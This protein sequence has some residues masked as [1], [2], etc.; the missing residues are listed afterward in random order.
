MVVRARPD[1]PPRGRGQLIGHDRLHLGSPPSPP[2]G[3][4]LPGIGL[5]GPGHRRDQPGIRPPGQ[6]PAPAP[7]DRPRPDPRPDPALASRA[8]T[9]PVARP[10]LGKERTGLWPH[11]DLRHDPSSPTHSWS[12]VPCCPRRAV[13][14]TASGRRVKGPVGRGRGTSQI[15]VVAPVDAP[16]GPPGRTLS[17]C[18]AA[19]APGSIISRFERPRA[20]RR[21]RPGTTS[22][23]TCASPA[24]RHCRSLPVIQ[25]SFTPR[26]PNAT[27]CVTQRP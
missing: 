25:A 18:R 20:V 7:P 21:S 1:A 8:D 6:T 10:S 9:S 26:S 24:R 2:P 15:G 13:W 5:P 11:G 23:L 19:E 4:Q 17:R 3:R 12:A 16:G 27:G 14:T 22:P